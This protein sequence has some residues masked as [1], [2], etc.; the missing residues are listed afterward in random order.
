MWLHKGLNPMSMTHTFVRGRIGFLHYNLLLHSFHVSHQ[1]KSAF[2]MVFK[3][4]GKIPVVAT[5]IGLQFFVFSVTIVQITLQSSRIWHM[6][7]LILQVDLNHFQDYSQ[8][9]RCPNSKRINIYIFFH[10]PF[11][12]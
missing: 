3:K 4:S 10:W 8:L 2:K 9:H 5:N 12:V 6:P 11:S 1:D 7:F